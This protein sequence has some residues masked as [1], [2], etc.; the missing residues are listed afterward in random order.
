MINDNFKDFIKIS[1][2]IGANQAFVQGG[3]GNTSLKLGA[4]E[5][6]IKASGL[7]LKDMTLEKGFSVVR[8]PNIKEYLE[9][10][11]KSEDLFVEKIKSYKIR[12]DARPSIETGF[13]AI[14]GQC[15][16]H[17][18]SVYA[19]TITCAEEG[20]AIADELF[21]K[22]IWVDY[23]SPGRE[24]TL[25]IKEALSNQDVNK[26]TVIFLQNHGLIISAETPEKA[27][28]LHSIVNSKIQERLNLS[29]F[30]TY[31]VESGFSSSAS[32]QQIL[33]PD[34][35]VYTNVD[36]SVLKTDAASETMK[37]YHY[38]LRNIKKLGLKPYFLNLVEVS[39][40]KNMESEKFR[41]GVL[42]NVHCS[43]SS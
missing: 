15:V 31:F 32:E 6:F 16:I 33:F 41:L 13:H 35:V 20:K 11:D 23:A 29:E 42:K 9:N 43:T 40:I 1:N 26:D 37:S 17:T 18:H 19:N 38:I 36:K 27:F 10:P 21:P 8:H 28:K 24:L 39:A 2:L 4:E 5:M 30:N 25:K 7:S 3:G 34:Q 12:T 14:L 22:S